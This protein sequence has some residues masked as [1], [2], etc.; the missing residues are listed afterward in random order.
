M[1]DRQTLSTIALSGS[2][3]ARY[4]QIDL[5]ELRVRMA[6]D[7]IKHGKFCCLLDNKR[8]QLTRS[9]ASPSRGIWMGEPACTM[10]ITS[11]RRWDRSTAPAGGHLARLQAGRAPHD[12]V[13]LEQERA[14]GVRPQ[15]R[16]LALLGEVVM[17]R[18]KRG[19]LLFR[20]DEVV[21]RHL[22]QIARSAD[23]PRPARSVSGSTSTIF[24]GGCMKSVVRT[25]AH[26][27]HVQHMQHMQL[28]VGRGDDAANE[29][30]PAPLLV[31]TS[32]SKKMMIRHRSLCQS[33]RLRMSLARATAGVF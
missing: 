2:H 25:W 15:D 26:A 16:L 19:Q 18:H 10:Q 1:S 23:L 17:L 9:G 13:G 12:L 14:Q 20:V 28:P 3:P 33:L 30:Q 5:A 29:Q 21:V 22:A 7:L 31:N 24:M 32:S 11:E 4:I 27:T 6:H 8:L